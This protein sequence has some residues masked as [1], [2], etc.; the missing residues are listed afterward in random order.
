MIHVRP[1][2]PDEGDAR[3]LLGELSGAL[4]KITGSTGAASFDR[5]DVEGE[6]GLFLL[7]YVDERPAGCGAFR[8][9]QPGVAEMKR[10]YAR[11]GTHGVGRALLE[12]LEKEAKRVGYL[13]VWL[14]TRAVNER[15]VRFYERHGYGR[16]DNFGK[17]VGRDEAVCFAKR[18]GST[19]V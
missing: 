10:M 9:L 18:L 11:P 2:T 19:L 12:R 5:A 6:G 7:A 1:A 4:E 15:A 14:E 16:I 3:L 17:Y 13:E 8:R